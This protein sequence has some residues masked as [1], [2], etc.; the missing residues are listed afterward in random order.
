MKNQL[1]NLNEYL[2]DTL[3]RITN[4]DLT[5]DELN[6]EINRSETI[7]KVAKAIIDNG[8]LALQAMKHLDEYGRGNQIDIPLLGI[9]A[10]NEKR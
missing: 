4:D 1:E 7:V 3:D 10:E 5:G 2:F 6:Q 9:K 8:S